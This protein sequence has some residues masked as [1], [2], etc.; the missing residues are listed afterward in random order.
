MRFPHAEG[1]VEVVLAIALW[2]VRFRLLRVGRP[3]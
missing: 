1:E 3:R 2:G